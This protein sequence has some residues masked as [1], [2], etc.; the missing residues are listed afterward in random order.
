MP[1]LRV[2]GAA[3]LAVLIMLVT[4]IANTAAA[5]TN[6]VQN[7]TFAITGGTTS[8]QFGTYNGYSSSQALGETLAGWSST[9]YNFVFLPTSTVATGTY[10]SLSLYSSVTTPSNSFNNASPTGGNFIA[11]DGDYGT[12]A[13]T[14]TINGLTVGQ[15]Y[16]VS[17]AWAG[18]Q[19][20]GYTGATTEQWDVTLGNSATQSTQVINIPSQGFSGWMNQTFNYVATSSSEVLSFLANGTPAGVP[21]FALLANV[22]VTQVPEPASMAVLLTGVAGLIGGTRR[23]RG[24]SASIAATG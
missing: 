18:A 5:Q 2:S 23:R 17:F 12:T 22:K 11:A 9:G 6:L 16:A 19:Q 14:Q 24:R 10:G 21:P 4:A 13:I 7:G 8:F 20:T 15:T 3:A 1:G